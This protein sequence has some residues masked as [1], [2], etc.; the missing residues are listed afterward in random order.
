MVKGLNYLVRRV[1]LLIKMFLHDILVESD[2]YKVGLFKEL[3]KQECP[4]CLVI[5]NSP[6]FSVNPL[7]R[8][9]S[10]KSSLQIPTSPAKSTCCVP[11]HL[12][13][14]RVRTKCWMRG[15]RKVKGGSDQGT[16]WCVPILYVYSTTIL[17][18]TFGNFQY[19]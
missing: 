8:Q 5:A 14:H 2:S 18:D 11:S 12:R 17:Y 4:L 10:R 19:I 1:N 9:S 3:K 6:V 7:P 15:T 16:K 13:I